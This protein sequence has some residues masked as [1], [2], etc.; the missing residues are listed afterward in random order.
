MD[1]VLC[2][3]LEKERGRIVYQDEHVFVLVNIEP[4]KDGHVMI[5]PVRHAQDLKDLDPNKS[6]AFLKAI[7]RC[8]HAVTEL[9]SDPPMCFVNGWSFRTQAHL[10]AHVL[11][12]KQGLRGLFSSSEGTEKRRRVDDALLEEMATRLKTVFQE[13]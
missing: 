6:A 11:P 2:D 13:I 7:D 1:C 10:H 3:S 4:I 12:S 5:L 8:M 9:F